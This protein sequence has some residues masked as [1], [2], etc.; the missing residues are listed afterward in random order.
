M[1]RDR[2]HT[3]RG[4]QRRRRGPLA[5]TG[6]TALVDVVFLLLLFLVLTARFIPEERRFD[7][8]LPENQRVP[9]DRYL[10]PFRIEVLQT[11]EG[12][13][14][15]A[16]GEEVVERPALVMRLRGLPPRIPVT[17]WGGDGV[18]YSAVVA[19]YDACVEAGRERVLL[20]LVGAGAGTG[21]G[22]GPGDALAR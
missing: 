16:G 1:A 6:M 22:A 15:T 12:T 10:E 20:S 18:P 19:A 2:R 9:V 17:V 13:L 4:G 3:G 8:K 11:A 14:T 5:S 7:L 21:V